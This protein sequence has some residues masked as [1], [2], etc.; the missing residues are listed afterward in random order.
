MNFDDRCTMT[1]KNGAN[2]GWKPL[3]KPE[4]ILEAADEEVELIL[5]NIPEVDKVAQGVIAASRR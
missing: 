4:H 3:Y 2:L 1:A 5:Q